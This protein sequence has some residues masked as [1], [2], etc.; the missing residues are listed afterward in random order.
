MGDPNTKAKWSRAS[1]PVDLVHNINHALNCNMCH[2]P[3]SA[4]PRIVRD[5]LIQAMTRTDYP[6]LYSES[7][8][9]TP[10]EVKDMG[11]R[12]L[13]RQQTHVRTVPR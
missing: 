1:N 2:D 6:T 4:Q 5:A 9:K 7:A 10:I 3:H 13:T 12:G 11:L 8:N